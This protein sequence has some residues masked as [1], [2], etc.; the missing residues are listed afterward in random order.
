MPLNA[1]GHGPEMDPAKVVRVQHEV[2]N[3]HQLSVATFQNKAVA[4]LFVAA[5]KPPAALLQPETKV[6]VEE[7]REVATAGSPNSPFPPMILRLAAALEAQAARIAECVPLRTYAEQ[8]SRNARLS[9][10]AEAAEAH[11][12][13][14][15]RQLAAARE[16]ILDE[17][18]SAVR[19]ILVDAAH[20]S[21]GKVIKRSSAMF[22]AE[23]FAT[24]AIVSM[25]ERYR[26]AN[27]NL[28][29]PPSEP[30]ADEQCPACAGKGWFN[31][32]CN[33]CKG[34]GKAPE[35][36]AARDLTADEDRM[37]NKALIASTELVEPI[38]AYSKGIA[39]GVMDKAS[40]PPAALLPPETK[41]L[42]EEA[43][44]LSF[45]TGY[46][47]EFARRV[48]A[49]LEAQ[50]ARIAELEDQVENYGAALVSISQDRMDG[51]RYRRR[52]RRALEGYKTKPLAC[53]QH[54]L[55]AAEA[56]AEAMGRKCERIERYAN[57]LLDMTVDVN[58]RRTFESFAALARGELPD[59]MKEAE[60]AALAAQEQGGEHG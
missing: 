45:H 13:A 1:E 39:L 27:A 49:A 29:A 30:R 38:E 23:T 47:G 54:K 36:P 32:K 25:K 41:G 37:L 42:L 58:K 5:L 40:K 55:Q 31:A 14:A 6:L 24:A 44:G 17:A 56:R 43:Q 19:Q 9:Y 3:G 34:S 11:A 52:A 28:P 22:K 57:M 50:A 10:R 18:E 21:G 8:V 20:A 48:T 12:K 53:M 46:I 7:A 2:W 35:P 26:A 51:P 60:A 4:E 59:W 16:D 33:V 15:E